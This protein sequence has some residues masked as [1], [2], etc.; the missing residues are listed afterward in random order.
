MLTLGITTRV[1]FAREP[2][3]AR[4]SFDTLAAV[5]TQTLGR[6]PLSGD[7][8]VFLNKRRNHLK[9]LAWHGDGYTIFMKRLQLGTFTL[10]TGDT[11]DLALTPTQLAMIL[12]GVDLANTTS[13]KR[14]ALPNSV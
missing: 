10:P 13:R 3:D 9:I 7:L 8:F 5:V 4:K 2:I 12:G 14:F 11:R 1:Y 6:D